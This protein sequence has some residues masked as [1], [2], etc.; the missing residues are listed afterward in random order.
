[1]N[2]WSMECVHEQYHPADCH[3]LLMTS[4]LRTRHLFHIISSCYPFSLDD[5]PEN[6]RIAR[7][8]GTSFT[9]FT[10]HSVCRCQTTFTGTTNDGKYEGSHVS[11]PQNLEELNH[12]SVLPNDCLRL[13]LMVWC[14]CIRVGGHVVAL[15]CQQYM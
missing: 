3:F 4:C 12:R 11:R 9:D 2:D 10:Y 5:T 7:K 8:D 14:P 15:G 6:T 13:T 1:M